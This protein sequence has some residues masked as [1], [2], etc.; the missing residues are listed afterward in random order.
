[1][2]WVKTRVLHVE[3]DLSQQHLV[4]I[5]LAQLAGYVVDTAPDGFRAI[6]IAGENAPDLILMDIGLPG[7]NGIETLKALHNIDR[8]GRVP[9]IF[10]T[11]GAGDLWTRIALLELSAPVL[12]KPVRPREL[13]HAILRALE[14][15]EP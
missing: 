6:E 7:L 15:R 2:T 9:A 12:R 3:D 13:V 1:M 4:R 10:M 14:P 8:L 11:A 5:A